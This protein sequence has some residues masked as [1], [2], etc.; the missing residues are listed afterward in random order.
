MR[1]ASIFALA[2]ACLCGL[3]IDHIDLHPPYHAVKVLSF[4]RGDASDSASGS[5]VQTPTVTGNVT[6]PGRAVEFDGVNDWVQYP[7]A[8]HLSFTDGAGTDRPFSV[9][10]WV[11]ADSLTGTRCVVSKEDYNGVNQ[12]EWA[13][14]IAAGKVQGAINAAGGNTGKIRTGNT[15]TL[16]TAT[17][18]FVAMTY[19]GS[20]TVAGIKLYVNGAEESAYTTT[21]DGTMNGMSNTA[22]KLYVGINSG[23]QGANYYDF[24]G[25]IDDVV[26]WST[27]LTS[28]EIGAMYAT[29]LGVTR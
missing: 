29:G 10:A 20:E 7:D 11:Y 4:N 13:F 17:W 5:Y 27:E 1:R 26:V 3:A 8:D 18:Y 12:S 28:A 14:N 25:K 21:S 24:D 23:T 9:T 16:S 22:A 2:L 15:T 19:S 6:F